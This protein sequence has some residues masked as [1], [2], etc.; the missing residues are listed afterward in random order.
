MAILS[1]IFPPRE[2]GRAIGIW[3]LGVVIGP[4]IGPTL[5]GILTGQF[6]WPSIFLVNVPIGLVGMYLANKVLTQPSLVERKKTSFDPVGFLSLSI[7]LVAMLLGVNSLAEGKANNSLLLWA[8]VASSLFI[9]VFSSLRV[10]NPLLD[11]RLLKNRKFT[12]CV[13]VTVARSGALYG[14]TH[15]IYRKLSLATKSRQRC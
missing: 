6:G 8:L 13:L 12:A 11:L 9:F 1:H 15:S 2:R 10:D 5:G 7:F 3:D 14:S 4:A